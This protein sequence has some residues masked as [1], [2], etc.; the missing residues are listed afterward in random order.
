MWNSADTNTENTF[1]KIMYS[2]GAIVAAALFAGIKNKIIQ[3]MTAIFK[4][5]LYKMLG[6]RQEQDQQGL[7]ENPDP[8]L[9]EDIREE[10]T[11]LKEDIEG[12]T[13]SSQANLQDKQGNRG[14]FLMHVDLA[15]P[16]LRQEARSESEL[17]EEYLDLSKLQKLKLVRSGVRQDSDSPDQG[18]LL[19]ATTNS[20]VPEYEEGE[21]LPQHSAPHPLTLAFERFKQVA[22]EKEESDLQ[23]KNQK[24][25][26]KK[27]G[28]CCVV[29]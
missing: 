1:S 20:Y 27:G 26:A 14:D 12:L 18:R 15:D 9:I 17:S 19:R 22:K 10:I 21:L 3:K 28:G 24:K 7:L 16:A 4:K 23:L 8:D 2:L 25:S 13:E 11:E 5:Q 29:S 6:I